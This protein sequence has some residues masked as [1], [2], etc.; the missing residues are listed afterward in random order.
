M[1]LPILALVHY[2]TLDFNKA[3]EQTTKAIES[4]YYARTTRADELKKRLADAEPKARAA[5]SRPEFEKVVNDMIDGFGDSHFD[6]FT[7]DDQGYYTMDNLTGGKL[8]LPQIGAWFR[9]GQDGYTVHMVLN[10]SEAEKAGL[11]KGDLIVSADGQP[12]EPVAS[13]R[14]KSK[15]HLKFRRGSKDFEKDVD[16]SLTT[17]TG[18]FLEASRRSARVI[19]S[20]GKKIGYFRLWTQ[21]SDDFR[22]ALSDALDGKL[23]DTD[24]FVLDL[25]DGFGGRPEGFGDPFFRPGVTLEWKFSPTASMKQSF[26]Y[27]KPL[28]VLINEGSRSAKEVLAYVFKYSH[29]ATLVGRNTA[30]NV[31]GTSPIRLNDWA[32]IEIPMVELM[33]DGVRLEGKGVAPDVALEKEYDENGKDLFLERALKIAATGKKD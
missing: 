13:F 12:F 32:V 33:T 16:V 26:G 15:V 31:L 24:A 5:K 3:W 27:G 25:R 30:G 11:V 8:E 6:F 10:D 20:G 22:K 1:L 23:R 17:A 7:D 18:M 2:Q 21:A 14:N 19:E 29:R 28:V 4:R 9:R